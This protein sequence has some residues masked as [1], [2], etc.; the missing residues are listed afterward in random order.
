MQ[1]CWSDETFKE[2]INA[3][4]I[5]EFFSEVHTTIEYD[6]KDV[7]KYESD[8]EASALLAESNNKTPPTLLR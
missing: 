3:K 6:Q 8:T 2:I 5:F 7:T 4:K 1:V